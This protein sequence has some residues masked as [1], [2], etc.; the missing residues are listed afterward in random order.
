MPTPTI[1][2][3]I[4]AQPV[5]LI[6]GSTAILNRIAAS[7]GDMILQPAELFSPVLEQAGPTLSRTLTFIPF[8]TITAT[9]RTIGVWDGDVPEQ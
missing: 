5:T 9:D 7:F 1:L 8:T 3:N 4:I 6:A 2:W